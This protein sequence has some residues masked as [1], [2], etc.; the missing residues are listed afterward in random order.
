MLLPKSPP[1]PCPVTSRQ[2]VKAERKFSAPLNFF[3][4]PANVENDKEQGE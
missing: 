3:S 4:G 1:D 2:T